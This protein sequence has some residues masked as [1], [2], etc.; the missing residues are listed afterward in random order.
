MSFSAVKA[1][2]NVG[3]KVFSQSRQAVTSSAF[4]RSFLG[5]QK[6]TQIS[7]AF[8]RSMWC[9]TASSNGSGSGIHSCQSIDNLGSQH[10]TRL[11]WPSVSQTCSCGHH[12]RLH[13]EGDKELSRFLEEEIKLEKDGKQAPE[14]I[15][16]FSLSIDGASATLS[17]TKDGDTIAVKFNVNHSVEAEDVGDEVSGGQDE[18]PTPPAMRAYP[19]FT[20]EI[21]KDTESVLSIKCHYTESELDEDDLHEEGEADVEKDLFLIDE[22]SIHRG[23]S[24][25]STYCVGSEVMDGTLYD[26]LLRMM[27]ERGVDNDFVEKLSDIATSVEH[28]NYIKFLEELKDVV[29]C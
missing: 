4:A 9:L 13:T 8:T 29:D 27:N 11:R 25:D 23:T 7:R 14:Q 6:E 21:T 10:V 15:P 20:V 3:R 16:G 18:E 24:S 19:D 12:A 28:G 5:V 26:M 17:K 1:A 22:V 2:T